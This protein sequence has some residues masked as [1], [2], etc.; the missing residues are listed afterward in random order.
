MERLC[1][2]LQPAF[3]TPVQ[4]SSVL[5]VKSWLRL[6]LAMIKLGSCEGMSSWRDSL[7]AYHWLPVEILTQKGLG[8]PGS[9]WT[10]HV[11][12]K[13]SASHIKCLRMSQKQIRGEAISIT[14]SFWVCF[15]VFSAHTLPSSVMDQSVVLC[16]DPK[17]KKKK[18]LPQYVCHLT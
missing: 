10:M 9:W 18:K 1:N 17:R 7:C 8:L 3:V 12:E 14:C 2:S 13:R 4:S 15:R 16:E 6:E 5:S 11:L